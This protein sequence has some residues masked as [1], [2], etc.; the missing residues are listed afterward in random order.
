MQRRDGVNRSNVREL[1]RPVRTEGLDKSQGD[2]ST[3]RK[4]RAKTKTNLKTDGQ[5]K[6][7]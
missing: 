3:A 6:R 4:T 2:G 7:K 5:T 1:E